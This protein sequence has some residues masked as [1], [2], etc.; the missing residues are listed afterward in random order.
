VDSTITLRV[1]EPV[2]V[3]SAFA[4]DCGDDL[5]D[6]LGGGRGAL[7]VRDERLVGGAVDDA[8]R[9]VPA[10][11]PSPGTEP[12]TRRRRPAIMLAVPGRRC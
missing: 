9:A 3:V 11:P 5:Q 2:R 1:G 4:P 6:G 10:P 12:P 8:V 7:L